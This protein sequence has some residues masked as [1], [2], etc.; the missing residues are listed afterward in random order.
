MAEFYAAL[1]MILKVLGLGCLVLFAALV[2][3]ILVA[4]VGA[5]LKSIISRK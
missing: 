5:V 4:C 3:I 1:I 2:F